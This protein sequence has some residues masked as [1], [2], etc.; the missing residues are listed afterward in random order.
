MK[1]KMSSEK[2]AI[3]GS[4][5]LCSIGDALMHIHIV[6]MHAKWLNFSDYLLL[7]CKTCYFSH[8]YR[9]PS[10]SHLTF[11]ILHED[12]DGDGD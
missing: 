4:A 3:S 9:T 5:K 7:T 12:G 6:L 8:T 2:H 10:A 11:D 1:K